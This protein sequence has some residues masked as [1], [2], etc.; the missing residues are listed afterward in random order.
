M[1]KRFQKLS[2]R[3]LAMILAVVMIVSVLPV[4]ALAVAASVVS[5]DL[6]DKNVIVGEYTEFT[7]TTTA[8]DDLGKMVFGYF[9]FN[10]GDWSVVE[11]LQY[12]ESRDGNWYDLIR[13]TPFGPAGTGFPMADATST[14]RVKFKTAGSYPFSVSMKTADEAKVELCALNQIVV[15]NPKP[16]EVTTNI[17]EVAFVAGTPSEFTFTAIPNDDVNE[18]VLAKVD[19]SDW[20]AVKTL[21][22]W[23]ETESKWVSLEKDSLIGPA[24]TGFL[25]TGTPTRMQVTFNRS[26]SYTCKV[27]MVKASDPTFELCNVEKTITVTDT[28]P[29]VVSETLGNPE[30]WAQSAVIKVQV[31]DEGGSNVA[32]VIYGT[33]DVVEEAVNEAVLVNGEYTFELIANGTYYIWAVDGDGNVSAAK[34][35]VVDKIDRQNPDLKVTT[36]PDAWTNGAV[37]IDISASDTSGVTV[38]YNTSE[39]MESATELTLKDDKAELVVSD[40]YNGSY[41]IWAEDAAGN[42]ASAIAKVQIDKTKPSVVIAEIST[43]W[44]NEDVV[45]NGTVA[46]AASGVIKVVYGTSEDLKDAVAA[47]LNGMEYHF[48]VTQNG[49]YWIWSQDLVGNYSDPQKIEFQNID[50]IKPTVDSVTAPLNWVKGDA[51]ITVVA[52]DDLS[53]VAKVIYGTDKE[54]SADKEYKEASLKE[55]GSYSFTIS[56]QDYEDSYYVWAIDQAGNVS[57]MKS[58]ALKM[59]KTLPAVISVVADPMEATNKSVTVSGTVSDNL[60]GIAKVV[61]GTDEEYSSEL[62]EASLKEDGSYSFVVSKDAQRYGVEYYVWAVDNAGNVS[63]KAN[64]T[65][66]IDIIAPKVGSATANHVTATNENV[67]ITVNVSDADSGVAR[68]VYGKSEKFGEQNLEA[69]LNENGEYTFVVDEEYRGNY[70]VWAIDNAGN[71][72]EPAVV[73]VHIDKTPAKACITAKSRIWEEFLAGITFGLYAA[74][75]L[76][77]EITATDIGSNVK[78]IFYIIADGEK[79]V[80]ELDAMQDWIAYTDPF[81]ITEEQKFVVYARIVDNAGNLVYYNTDGIVLDKTAASITLTTSD[82]VADNG[83]EGV[84]GYYNGDV[85]IDVS[86]DDSSKYS[87]IKSIEYWVTKDGE[88]TQRETLYSFGYDE[89]INYKETDKTW[90]IVGSDVDEENG[91]YT[92][93]PTYEM[94]KKNWA[95]EFTVYAERNNSSNVVVTVQVTDNAGNVTTQEIKLDI[96]ISEPVVNLAYDNGESEMSN[97]KYFNGMRTATITVMERSDHFLVPTVYIN[98][99][100]PEGENNYIH[101]TAVDAAGEPVAFEPVIEW[102]TTYDRLEPDKALHVATIEYD[103][104]ANYVFDIKVTDAAT[105]T[106]I[107]AEG[108]ESVP[109][110]FTVDTIAPVGS[111]SIEGYDAW[112]TLLEALT[113][114]IYTKESFDVNAAASDA[115]SPIKVEYCVVS[116]DDAVPNGMAI[117]DIETWTEVKL[118]ELEPLMTLDESERYVIYL[119]ITDMAG[120]VTHVSTDGLIMDDTGAAIALEPSDPVADN[121]VEGVY[122]Y[123]NDDV[124]IDVSVD[125]SSSYSGIKSI[126]YWVTND[127]VETQRETLYSFGYDGSYNAELEWEICDSSAEEKIVSCKGIPTYEMLMK[128]WESE[129]TVDAELN[130]SSN[131]VVTVQVADNAGNVTTQEIKLDIDEKK[132]SAPVVNLTYDNGDSK[133]FN[134]KY[135]NGTRTATITVMERPEHFVVPTVYI[136]KN[137]PEGENN[138][139]HITAVNAA[140]EPVAFEPVIEW[141]TTYDRLEPDKTL[142]VATIEYNLDAN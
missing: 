64:V 77:V 88:E 49:T 26:G 8:N 100:V 85:T 10:D 46:D 44:T 108:S 6:G 135:F 128:S 68:V 139:I 94:L 99:N 81:E 73:S 86:V 33:N 122:G 1:S 71:H 34:S 96:D 125:D 30:N 80:E 107:A 79:T 142:H 19:F 53:G 56:A 106:G 35:I 5:T 11:S 109:S 48:T 39:D 98:E 90:K 57:E 74:D 111:V 89:K 28:T 18:Y 23:N 31:T 55:D 119:R 115:T 87:G 15:A 38:K 61:Y 132:A 42:V 51:V 129:I 93:A 75:D 40:E 67:T 117:D 21:E 104:D 91:T 41:Y 141:G 97:E 121:G 52:S 126:E 84:Y 66:Y 60:S 43:D 36:D 58:V 72:S 76:S 69:E 24:D 113:F 116:G 50:K 92:G 131:V 4:S 102:D 29:P 14:F 27:A 63:E 59:D 105:N 12:K 65:V 78:N 127:G 22:Y 112:N 9:E 37:T 110:A 123:Y 13:G 70:Y 133:M 124:T 7:V 47:E 54:Y 83:V 62:A 32:K 114:G 25:M 2:N 130:N 138:Y 140:G 137:V 118:D 45:V 134:E 17:A 101:I 3:V 82:P 20:D 16:S 95:G 120:H 103:V 136:N